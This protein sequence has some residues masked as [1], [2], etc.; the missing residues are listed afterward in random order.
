MAKHRAPISSPLF[1]N[2]DEEIVAIWEALGRLQT[3]LYIQ[4][5]LAAYYTSPAW[6]AARNVVDLGT[7]NGY[8]LR[9][10]ARRFPDK[11]YLGVDDYSPMVEIARRQLRDEPVTFEECDLF[12]VDGRFDFAVL[13]FV[14]QHLPDVDALLDLLVKVIEP[15]GAVLVIDADDSKRCFFPEASEFMQFFSAYA[16]RESRDGRD[17]DCAESLPEKVRAQPKLTIGTTHE[18]L[19][20]STVDDILSILREAY[21]HFIRLVEL[22]GRLEYDFDGVRAAWD[23]WCALRDA[24]TQVGMVITTIHRQN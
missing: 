2:R 22:A 21:H 23:R 8:Y 24:Y 10:I 7:G 5:E 1:A 19:V 16:E 3:N 12:D 9:Q 18:I 6:H 4:Q 13:R 15:G 17:R 11:T 20:P 14:V